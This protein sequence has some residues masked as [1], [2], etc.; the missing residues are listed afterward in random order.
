M[1]KISKNFS[2]KW[3]RIFYLT[4]VVTKSRKKRVDFCGKFLRLMFISPDLLIIRRVLREYLRCGKLCVLI[5]SLDT[6]DDKDESETIIIR[7]D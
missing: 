1:V 3:M 2:N 7:I 6:V 5:N 4:I